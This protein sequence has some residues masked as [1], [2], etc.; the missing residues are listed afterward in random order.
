MIHQRLPIIGST[1]G[2]SPNKEIQLRV[3]KGE[4][5]VSLDEAKKQLSLNRRVDR[6][7]E[8]VIII[9]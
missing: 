8:G 9:I 3:V 4:E 7:G 2:D 1:S 5:F 6:D